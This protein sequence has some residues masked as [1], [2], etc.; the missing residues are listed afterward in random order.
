MNQRVI[1]NILIG[2]YLFL[3]G[4]IYLICY[5]TISHVLGIPDSS[6][7]FWMALITLLCSFFLSFVVQTINFSLNVR[8][9]MGLFSGGISIFVLASIHHG[10]NP[11]Q[12]VAFFNE[13]WADAV[14][15]TVSLIFLTILWWRG[16][17]IARDEITLEGVRNVFKSEYCS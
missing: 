4:Y 3:E 10:L 1:K 8:G 2:I 16:G 9:V 6:I 17:L 14:S 13:S 11:F 15:Y 12:V 7:P 5:N